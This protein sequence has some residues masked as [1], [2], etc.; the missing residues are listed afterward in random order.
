ML[1]I[2]FFKIPILVLPKLDSQNCHN[3]CDDDENDCEKLLNYTLDAFRCSFISLLFSFSAAASFQPVCTKSLLNVNSC[4]LFVILSIVHST[5]SSWLCL[6]MPRLSLRCIALLCFSFQM[7]T[8][9]SFNIFE[10]ADFEHS[11]LIVDVDLTH[12]HRR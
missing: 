6:I 1:H 8:F 3:I 4:E 10:R 5:V 11:I 7:F 12:T 2:T 9:T